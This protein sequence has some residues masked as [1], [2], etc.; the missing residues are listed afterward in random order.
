MSRVPAPFDFDA[1]R[2]AFTEKDLEPWLAFYAEDAE[3]IEYKPTAPPRAPN[4]MP[5]KRAIRAF[6]TEIAESDLKLSISDEV[7]GPG[8][9]AF[10][11]TCEL[12]GGRRFIENTIATI[13]D[14]LIV[15]Q[16]D[17]EAWD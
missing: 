16:V 2:R 5:D 10:C 11:V 1:Y 6:L 17:V 3:W 13:R 9:V 8:G 7:V 12:E 4:R 14:G 15:R